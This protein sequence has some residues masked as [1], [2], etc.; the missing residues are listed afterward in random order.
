VVFVVGYFLYVRFS[1]RSGFV[2]FLRV[3]PG[4][5]SAGVGLLPR[6]RP[7]PFFDLTSIKHRSIRPKDV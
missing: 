1:C 3:A 4:S 2:R 6:F 5:R 7:I